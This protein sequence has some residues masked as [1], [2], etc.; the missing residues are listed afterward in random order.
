HLFLC[1]VMFSGILTGQQTAPP[2]ET[3]GAPL[4]LVPSKPFEQPPQPARTAE[5]AKAPAASD[6]GA[7]PAVL[8]LKPAGDPIYLVEDPRGESGKD[9][10]RTYQLP[11]VGRF[12][13][14]GD[15]VAIQGYD[16]VS[17]QER[18]AEKGA[19]EF[20]AGYGGVSWRFAT[21][22]HRNL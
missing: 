9:K 11:N 19:K 10:W 21:A 20:S 8:N 16:V 7:R 2:A 14:N 22:D 1:A 18:R 4:Q 6:P 17:Y 3:Q 13:R 5:P 15:G 12:S